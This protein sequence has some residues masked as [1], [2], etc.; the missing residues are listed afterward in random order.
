QLLEAHEPANRGSPENPLSPE[1]IVAKFR[2]NGGSV[3]PASTVSAL[4][5]EVLALDQ[6]PDVRRVLELCRI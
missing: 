5:G 4:E 1:A 6:S 3:L 2:R